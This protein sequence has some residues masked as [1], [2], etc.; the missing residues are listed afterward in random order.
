[1]KRSLRWLVGI[2]MLAAAILWLAQP[3]GL[4]GDADL[5]DITPDLANGERLY[6]LGGCASC[7]GGPNE[8]AGAEGRLGGGMAL[9]SPVGR[10]MVPNIS[11]NSTRCGTTLTMQ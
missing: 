4:I 11:D 3:S 8:D 9:E 1:M 2:A 7:H 6:H 10:F 5:P